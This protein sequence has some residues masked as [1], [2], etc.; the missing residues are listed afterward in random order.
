MTLKLSRL[1]SFSIII[2][3]ITTVL[4]CSVWASS[5]LSRDYDIDD[6]GLVEIQSI[7]DLHRMM[8]KRG[9]LNQQP[10]PG[11]PDQKCIGFELTQDLTFPKDT[12]PAN[13]IE[14]TVGY[15]GVNAKNITLASPYS[16][17]NWP[18][19]KQFNLIFEGNGY[20]ISN[21]SLN[22]HSRAMFNFSSHAVFRNMTVS[23]NPKSIRRSAVLVGS[24]FDT[25]FNNVTIIEGYAVNGLL[26]S[27]VNTSKIN[28]CD[29]KGEVEGSHG[30]GL[31]MGK[32]IKTVVSIC[33]IQGKVT[34]S[35]GAGLIA[36]KSDSSEFHNI[37]V[38]GDIVGRF[39]TAGG[40]GEV[41]NSLLS[42]IT[43][44]ASVTGV[45]LSVGGIAGKLEGSDIRYSLFSGSI[46]ANSSAAG[47]IAGTIVDSHLQENEV[48][49]Q[50]VAKQNVGLIAGSVTNSTVKQFNFS[51]LA[52]LDR[53][54][55][56]SDTEIKPI[57]AW[58]AHQTETIIS[59]TEY[60]PTLPQKSETKSWYSS[61][62]E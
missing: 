53:P 42:H 55:D 39:N 22:K 9:Q 40:I 7:D 15:R 13:D 26:A 29:L 61:M 17:A 49:A 23:M 3:Q 46:Y 18:V 4:A 31:L 21:L 60:N 28:I 54:S 38:D 8:T 56:G 2:S 1:K 20:H 30:V 43:V 41:K 48:D 59:N 34:A 14:K 5:A 27:I 62:F 52:K 11:C 35:H 33:S 36:G 47:G 16:Q 25:E 45:H 10:Y 51:G 32:A 19:I 57:T 44:Q 58:F 24:A 12:A 37:T 50:I 6:D